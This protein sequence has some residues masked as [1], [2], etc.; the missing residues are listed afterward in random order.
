MNRRLP[1][2]SVPVLSVNS[3][4]MSPRSSTQTSRLTSTLRWASC[5]EPAAR[6][7]ETTAGSSCGEIPTAIDSENSSASSTGLCS[8]TL[9]TKIAPVSAPATWT[10]SIENFRS[11]T[12]NSVSGCCCP[13]PTA[14]RPNSASPPVATTTPVPDPARTTVPISAQELSSASGV[15]APTGPADFSAG[16][17]SP[18]STDSSHSRP[19]TASSRRSAGTRKSR[20][21]SQ[22]G[23][24]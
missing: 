8:A 9:M 3:T 20:A 7:V 14:I 12:W 4:S 21:Y 18:V 6:L 23:T 16:R 24:A 19:A 13:R 15:P 1:S 11:P 10:S 2:V 5:R 22:A 17:D